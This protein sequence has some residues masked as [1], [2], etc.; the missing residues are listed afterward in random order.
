M[1]LNT[2]YDKRSLKQRKVDLPHAVLEGCSALVDQLLIS[3]LDGISRLLDLT[4]LSTQ[5]LTLTVSELSFLH[6]VS[7]LS[8]SGPFALD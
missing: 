3:L 7:Q 2:R 5:P 4:H 8:P 6:L 1:A